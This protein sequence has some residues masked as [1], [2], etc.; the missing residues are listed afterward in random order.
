MTSTEPP[1]A[2]PQPAPE[3]RFAGW[4]LIVPGALMVLLC[5]GCTLTFWG[6]GL[7]ALVQD[8]SGSAWG[9]LVGLFFTSLLIGGLP[10][11]GGAILVWAGWRALHPLRTPRDAA[12]TFE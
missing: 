5:G 1:P 6:V 2:A 3:A 12:K 9:A 11:A 4:I 8:H 10:A 7:V